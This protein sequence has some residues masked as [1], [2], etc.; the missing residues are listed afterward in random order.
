MKKFVL[1]A[2]LAGVGYALYRQA[3][4]QRL[5]SDLWTEATSPID[6]R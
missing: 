1:F 3:E 2:L 4:S 5:E 6:L